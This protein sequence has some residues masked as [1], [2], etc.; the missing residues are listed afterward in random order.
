MPSTTLPLPSDTNAYSEPNVKLLNSN[1]WHPEP[2]HIGNLSSEQAFILQRFKEEIKADGAWNEERMDD[3]MLLRFLRARKFDL[4]KAKKMLLDA[5]KWRQEFGVDDLVKNFNFIEREEVN[6]YYPR[7][8]HKTD[9]DG[10]PVYIERLGHIDFN[11]LSSLTTLDRLLKNLVCE[12]EKCLTTRLPACSA[13]VGHPV[14]ST[15]T[16]LD[17][18]GV[19]LGSFYRV[20]DY[21]LAAAHIGQNMY[22][23][24]MGR[25][26]VVNAP[27]AFSVVW[28]VI[29]PWL[30]EVTARKIKILG[31]H[32]RE[33]VLEQ[34]PGDCLPKEHFGGEC[35]CPCPGGCQ[36]SD[37]GPWN[38]KLE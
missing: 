15:C 19:S 34:I 32:F 31:G 7:Y 14:E 25:F 5:E 33:V 16:I 18:R 10:R 23:E 8:Y 26:Y 36:M 17:L 27:W 29:R 37:A 30:D 1:D 24:T 9:K 38:L 3:A 22:P 13:A 11:V 2:G 35:E 6:K 12:Y 21:V 28:R 4:L 20:K